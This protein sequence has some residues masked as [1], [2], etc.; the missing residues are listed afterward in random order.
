MAGRR[1]SEEEEEE[2][3]P[4]RAATSSLASPAWEPY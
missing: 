2:G 4:G 1:T 3:E